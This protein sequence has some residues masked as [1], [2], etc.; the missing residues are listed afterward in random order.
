MLTAVSIITASIACSSRGTPVDLAGHDAAAVE[1]QQHRLV[2][3]GAVGADDDLS[4]AGGGR[5][6][7]AAELV[8]G[9]VLAQLI[10]L[11]ARAASLC[12]AK[13]DFED[14]SPVDPQ[15]GFVPALERGKDLED[16]VQVT[17]A[18]ARREPERSLDADGQVVDVEA[19]TSLRTRW[20]S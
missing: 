20:S 4:G 10:E 12:G 3:L 9:R 2:A 8:V 11:G 18:L 5:P 17:G 19:T 16:G 6:V 14:A 15:L 13:A 1:Q 7:D